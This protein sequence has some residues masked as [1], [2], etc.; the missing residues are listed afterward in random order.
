[1]ERDITGMIWFAIGC[2]FGLLLIL[3]ISVSLTFWQEIKFWLL[4][5]KGNCPKCNSKLMQKDVPLVG[6]YMGCS[7]TGCTNFFGIKDYGDY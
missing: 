6:F 1:M 4:G 2:G 5:N 3:F 7:N